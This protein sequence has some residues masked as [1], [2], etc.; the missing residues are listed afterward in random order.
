[1]AWQVGLKCAFNFIG[2]ASDQRVIGHFFPVDHAV[3]E[4][5]RIVIGGK[6]H[7][8]APVHR[9][10]AP[11]I[12]ELS[13]KPNRR[14]VGDDLKIMVGQPRQ[15][16]TAGDFACADQ[17]GWKIAFI[18]DCRTKIGQGRVFKAAGEIKQ[19]TVCRKI[20]NAGGVKIL[21]RWIGTA[22]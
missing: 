17:F 3:D 9:V 5:N 12:D 18:A 20:G 4:I 2:K 22:I 16:R 1:M 14:A 19:H 15:Q 13:L 10:I 11:V 6:W 7:Q 21:N 8:D